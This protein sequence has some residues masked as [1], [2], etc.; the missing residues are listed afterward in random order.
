MA[1]DF[2]NVVALGTVFVLGSRLPTSA[3]T[4]AASS[5]AAPTM[6]GPVS[7]PVRASGGAPVTYLTN[8]R[9]VAAMVL[10]PMSPSTLSVR[11]LS[12]IRCASELSACCSFVTPAFAVG[13]LVAGFAAG[14]TAAALFTA[15]V[16]AGRAAA[17]AT[18]VESV[19]A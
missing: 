18:F 2:G 7:L 6:A 4:A 13:L 9:F 16:A 17:A 10:G 12:P 1:P 19:A 3:S 15:A 14:L 11:P 8:A 5:S